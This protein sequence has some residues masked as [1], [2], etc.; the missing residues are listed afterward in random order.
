ML[1]KDFQTKFNRWL[2]YVYKKTGAFELKITHEK[3]IPFSAVKDH[4]VA[5][6]LAAKG[7][8]IAYKISDESSGFKPFD[9][10]FLNNVG[11]WVVIWYYNNSLQRGHKRL[12]DVGLERSSF[13]LIDVDDWIQEKSES[14]RKSLTEE[15]AKEIG[16]AY[17]FP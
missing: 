15:R 12:G 1:E 7:E 3:S 2:R 13:Y 14:K 17:S 8:G 5:A 10:F 4:Q 9:C 16:E 6:L 11:G